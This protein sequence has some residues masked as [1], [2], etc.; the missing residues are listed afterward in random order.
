M[1]LLSVVWDVNPVM[2]ELGPLQIRYYGL[3]FAMGFLIGYFI[4]KHFFVYENAP[5]KEIDKMSMYIIVG[6]VIGARLGHCLF[7]EPEV[8][9]KD[10]I[11]I[12]FIWKGGLASHGGAVGLL[13]GLWLYSR[14]S[15]NKSMLHVLDRIAIPTA[16]A[17]SFIRLGNLFNSEI[18]GH[19]TDLPWGFIY[20]REGNTAPHHPT[21]IY[22]ALSYL[23]I[24]IFLFI[25]YKRYKGIINRGLIAGWLATLIFVQRFFVEF[26]K[27]DQVDFES[28][29]LLNM[30]QILSIPFIIAGI[31]LI[32]RSKKLGP[33]PRPEFKK[34][35]E[36]K[37]DK[38]E[39]S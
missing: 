29:M 39:E 27:N 12:L 15:W 22:E 2:V 20:V 28:D 17:A 38:K 4:V 19:E 33:A 31:V 35:E 37:A 26:L 30:G 24:F 25:L 8:Y 16:L 32:I 11:Q 13:I 10:P 21:Q 23:L 34:S 14:K 9:L 6:A 7:Y 3:L 18:Y 1:S 36:K 5:L